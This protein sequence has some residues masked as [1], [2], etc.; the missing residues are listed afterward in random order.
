MLT[1]RL[2]ESE[3]DRAERWTQIETLTRKLHESEVDRSARWTQ[4]EALTKKLVES[5][6]NYASH[7]AKFE[8]LTSD[9]LSLLARPSFRWLNK[10][11]GW[12][13]VKKWEKRIES[14]KE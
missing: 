8:G 12:P 11:L 6:A 7:S 13:E 9:L 5:E 4:I 2:K 14:F 1:N 10:I 3:D